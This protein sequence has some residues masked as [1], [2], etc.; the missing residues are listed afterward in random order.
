MDDKTSESMMQTLK[1]PWCAHYAW[2]CYVTEIWAKGN[3]NSHVET[4]HLLLYLR[5]CVSVL[6]FQVS[7]SANIPNSCTDACVKKPK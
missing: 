5:G 3:L 6:M 1:F 7:I 4:I 2:L